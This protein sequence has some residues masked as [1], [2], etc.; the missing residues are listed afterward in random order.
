MTGLGDLDNRGSSGAM[1]SSSGWGELSVEHY[2]LLLMHRKLLI[3]ITFLV[4]SGGAALYSYLA[5]N[6]YTSESLLLV[7][8]QQIPERYVTSTVPGDIRNRLN[9]LV[10]QIMSATRLKTIIEKF[11]LYQEQQ[12][13]LSHEEIISLMRD[14]ISVTEAVDFG[15][16]AVTNLQA[17]RI[18][19]SGQDA[20]IVAQVANELASLFIEENLKARERVAT[21]T[22]EFIDNQVEEARTKLIAQ[23]AE[24]SK[25]KLQHVGEMPDQQQANLQILNQLQ[26]QLQGVNDAVSRAEQQKTYLQAL[27]T[28]QSSPAEQRNEARGTNPSVRNPTG[29]SQEELLLAATLSRYGETHPDVQQLRKQIEELRQIRQRSEQEALDAAAQAPESAERE[30]ATTPVN[31]AF[32]ATQAQLQAI[33]TEIAQK[34]AEQK[35]LN[36]MISTYQARV[37]SAPIRE[38]EMLQLVRDYEISKDYY[39]QLLGKKLS[40]ET[41]T[42]LEIRQKGERFTIVDAAQ[43]PEKP[44]SPN[45]LL[46]N[47]MGCLAGLALGLLA[48]IATEFL[49]ITIT[50]PNQVVAATR[51]A[52]LGIIPVLQTR[53]DHRRRRWA[54]ACAT[55]GAVTLLLGGTLLL[56]HFRNQIF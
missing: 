49:G 36:D 10:Q 50:S 19:Y 43:V 27:I 23:E 53:A 20:R 39:S 25:Y 37:E 5:P 44:S 29:P 12:N 30:P 38:Q 21:G 16:K 6:V 52:V 14:D 18:S 46:I 33:E 1:K 47:A 40:S 48:A 26:S 45:R 8:P 32:S 9:S 34:K 56:Y 24:L 35:R 11:D 13:K 17:F 4:V 41:S 42:Q 2:I 28:T 55:S 7:D 22:T 31:P 15:G 51:L 3:L 54:I